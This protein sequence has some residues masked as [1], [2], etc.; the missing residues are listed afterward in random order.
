MVERED[1]GNTHEM[2]RS[3]GLVGGQERAMESTHFFS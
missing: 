3:S 2:R 1:A